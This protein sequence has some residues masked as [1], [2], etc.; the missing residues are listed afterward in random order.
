M[1]VLCDDI[2]RTF[3]GMSYKH[4]IRRL[5]RQG[6]V[7][8]IPGLTEYELENDDQMAYAYDDPSALRSSGGE[9]TGIN[10]S[11]DQMAYALKA[12]GSETMYDDVTS[13]RG[14][15]TVRINKIDDQMA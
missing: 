6:G 14:A 4:A 3:Q 8:I 2:Q 5:A 7:K 9:S 13:S 11:D 12:K 15:E 1:K 10:K